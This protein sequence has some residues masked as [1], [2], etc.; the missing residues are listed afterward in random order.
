MIYFFCKPKAVSQQGETVFF[1]PFIL[2][3]IAE[4]FLL[5]ILPKDSSTAF[6][7]SYTQKHSPACICSSAMQR[8]TNLS[9]TYQPE[10]GAV[11]KSRFLS[12]KF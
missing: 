3:A 8:G 12:S 9:M 4:E 6:S 1:Y 2:V 11:G 5:A 10:K 7:V